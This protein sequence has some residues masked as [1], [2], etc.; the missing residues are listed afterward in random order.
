MVE[1]SK[2]LF[3]SA[4]SKSQHLGRQGDR[5][6]RAAPVL[7]PICQK[8]TSSAAV[9]GPVPDPVEND[10]AP[11]QALLRR[12]HA[13]DPDAF[14]TLMQSHYEPVFRLVQSIIRD[15][16]AARDVCQE[17]WLAAWRNLKSFRGEAKFSTWIHPI[18][19]R[20]AID[21]LRRRRRWYTRFLPFLPGENADGEERGLSLIHI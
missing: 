13:G 2:C 14:G 19:V 15:E 5:G 10:N 17:I 9:G 8:P 11:E 20:R 7:R 21:H 4:P 16:H 6:A 18:A 12:A 3:G 1:T